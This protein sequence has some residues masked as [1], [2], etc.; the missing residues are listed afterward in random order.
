MARQLVMV[1]SVTLSRC[2]WSRS[3]TKGKPPLRPPRLGTRAE[4]VRPQ[5]SG[6]TASVRLWV[7]QGTDSLI[8]AAVSGAGFSLGFRAAATSTLSVILSSPEGGGY[9]GGNAEART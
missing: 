5:P 2:A 3:G 7:S 9:F 6:R 4:L 1:N 8:G